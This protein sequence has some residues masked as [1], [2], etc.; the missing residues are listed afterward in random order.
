MTGR[1]KRIAIVNIPADVAMT[2][3]A[4]FGELRGATTVDGRDWATVRG[5]A[6]IRSPDGNWSIGVAEENLIE[7]KAV[8]G[9][10]YPPSYSIGMHELAHALHLQG[11]TRAQRK[12]LETL[13]ARHRVRDEGNAQGTWS[14]NYAASNELEYFAQSTI[15]YFGRNGMGRNGNGRPWVQDNDPEMYAFLASLYENRFDASGEVAA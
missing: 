7:V 8:I 4:E 2:D 13:Y 6:G 1:R 15:A 3:T 14:D 9:N 5:S 11:M 10:P 12:Q